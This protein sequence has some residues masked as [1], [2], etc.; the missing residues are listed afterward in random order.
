MAKVNTTLS[1]DDVIKE[2]FKIATI[3]NK[4]DMS[5]TVEAFMQRYVETSN[6]LRK[7]RAEKNG[8]Q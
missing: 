5:E 1:I 6:H 8:Q 3:Q 2:S 7:Q 4:V